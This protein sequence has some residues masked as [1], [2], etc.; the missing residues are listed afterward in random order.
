MDLAPAI[1]DI[2][3]Q[4]PLLP[5]E[6]TWAI[7]Q[8][9]GIA[10]PVHPRT[11]EPIVLTTDFL[12]TRRTVLTEHMQARTVKYAKDLGSKR[13]LEKLEIERRYWMNRQTDWGILTEHE[14][15]PALAKNLEWLHPFFDREALAPLSSDTIQ[16]ASQILTEAVTAKTSPLRTVTSSCDA[17]LNLPAGTSLSITRHLLATRQWI[18][19]L[20]V[21][22]NPSQPLDLR[23][24]AITHYHPPS[25]R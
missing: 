18:V 22:I 9:C 13:T 16:H 20:R 4:Y 7:A 17:T 11:R 23:Q 5:V 21:L 1:T 14:I 8:A 6:D 12:L 25:T 3:E 15:P 10:H 2:R 24:T 19:D